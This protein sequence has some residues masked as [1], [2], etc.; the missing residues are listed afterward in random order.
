MAHPILLEAPFP[1]QRLFVNSNSRYAFAVAPVRTGKTRGAAVAFTR[2]V[3]QD[4]KRFPNN[5]PVGDELNYW[6]LG[7]TYDLTVSQKEHLLRFITP[8]MV[9]YSRQG[10]DSRWKNTN[11]GDGKICLVGGRTITFK[12]GESNLIAATVRG[13]WLTEAAR[14]PEDAWADL[15]TR[16]SNVDYPGGPTTRWMIGDTTPYGRGWFYEQVV[17]GVATGKFKQC[18]MHGWSFADSAA[19]GK[20]VD[21]DEYYL[22]QSQM[23]ELFFRRDYNAEWVAPQGQVFSDFDEKLNVKVPHDFPGPEW[24]P[25]IAADLN[26]AAEKPACYSVCWHHRESDRLH[27]QIE[28]AA[29]VGIDLIEYP[30]VLVKEAKKR[31]DALIVL[32]P[33]IRNEIKTAIQRGGAMCVDGVAAEDAGVRRLATLV[34]TRR[35][36]V[37]P[38]CKE[39]IRQFFAT[40]WS[41]NPDK[42]GLYHIDKKKCDPHYLDGVRYLAL[43]T[44]RNIRPKIKLHQPFGAHGPQVKQV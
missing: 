30:E 23:P 19:S 25:Y 33:S 26:S 20:T 5:F 29:Y 8:D 18:E 13:I 37:D 22:K 9:D 42:K 40:V 14:L 17:L 35:L 44:E 21:M 27:M 16:I 43:W 39:T 38:A 36:T 2:R 12:S 10:G 41:G 7:P 28:L 4:Y 32:D 3:F 6:V 1:K 24:E 34:K 31:R 11:R 15:T